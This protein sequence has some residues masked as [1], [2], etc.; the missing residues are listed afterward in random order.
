M[1]A[2]SIQAE[3]PLNLRLHPNEPQYAWDQAIRQLLGRDPIKSA[4]KS[5][6]NQ[7]EQETLLHK[8]ILETAITQSCSPSSLKQKRAL[9][10]INH[11]GERERERKKKRLAER[12]TD[13]YQGKIR[14]LNAQAS[15]SNRIIAERDAKISGLSS[16]LAKLTSSTSWK[17]TRPL[18]FANLFFHAPVATFYN[19]LEFFIGA[20]LLCF[21]N[22]YKVPAIVLFSLDLEACAKRVLS[23]QSW[24]G[25][26]YPNLAG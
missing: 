20:C 9:S 17:I 7:L 18:R 15:E 13:H 14:D 6:T 26:P 11:E 12:I 21:A 5:K 23:I 2:A 3:S 19:L 24:R 4:P 16:E 10:I 8:Q 25:T 22:I 1:E